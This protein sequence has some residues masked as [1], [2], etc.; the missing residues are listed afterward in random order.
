MIETTVIQRVQPS[1]KTKQ[2]HVRLTAEQERLLRQYCIRNRVSTSD[3]IVGAL[4]IKIDGFD[5]TVTA[6]NGHDSD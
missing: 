2:A 3:A 4:A 6:L 5:E 1:P